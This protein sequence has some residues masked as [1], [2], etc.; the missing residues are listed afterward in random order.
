[1]LEIKVTIEDKLIEPL[2]NFS[3]LATREVDYALRDGAFLVEATVKKKISGGSRSGVGYRVGKKTSVRSAPGQ[4]PKSDTGR[5]VS[6][7][8]HEF[9]YLNASVGTNVIY[10]PYLELGTSKMAARPYLQPSLDE[11]KDKISS[12]IESALIRAMK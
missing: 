9:S 12:L 7:I 2:K 1:L 4:P 10:A 11:N 5:L 8:T 3:Y 6:S